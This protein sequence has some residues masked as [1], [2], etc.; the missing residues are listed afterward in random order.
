MAIVDVCCFGYSGVWCP[1]ATKVAAL[2]RPAAVPVL[3]GHIANAF[4]YGREAFSV[5][6]PNNGRRTLIDRVVR[7][8]GRA[9]YDYRDEL[10]AIRDA[11]T[12]AVPEIGQIPNLRLLDIVAWTAQ[13]DRMPRRRGQGPRWI[14][15]PERD[16]MPLED[17]GPAL[18]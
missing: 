10:A 1:K 15:R 7:A 14:D 9:L 13:D 3:D 6:S 5:A 16:R 2:F 4:G 11:A 18:I 17:F 12:T 8:L